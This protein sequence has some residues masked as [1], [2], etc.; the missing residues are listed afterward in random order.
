MPGGSYQKP[1]NWRTLKRRILER[2]GYRCLCGARAV[3]ADHIIPRSQGGGDDPVNLRAI[4]GPCHEAKSKVE[5]AIGR[6]RA[7]AK[8]R[9]QARLAPERHPGRIA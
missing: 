7:S 6:R 8:R 5:A 2:D 3:T 4:C 1:G 9:S